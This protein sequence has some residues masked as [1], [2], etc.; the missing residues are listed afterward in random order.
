VA[1]Q[2]SNGVGI[3]PPRYRRV[4]I[5]ISMVSVTHDG[6]A[7]RRDGWLGAVAKAD[8]AIFLLF[9]PLAAMAAEL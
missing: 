1:K 4:P 3:M 5:W 2:Y 7:N 9:L 6:C 8:D